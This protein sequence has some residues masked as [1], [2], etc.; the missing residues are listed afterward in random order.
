MP[1]KITNEEDRVIRINICVKPKVLRALDKNVDRIAQWL[2]LKG[3]DVKD[4]TRIVTRSALI[5]EM[6]SSLGTEAGYHS[7]LMGF[8]MALGVHGMDQTE[9]FEGKE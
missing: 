4:V 1:R 5:T 6:V 7:M 8:S 3:A 9:L 2:I